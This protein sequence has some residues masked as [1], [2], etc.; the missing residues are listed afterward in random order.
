MVQL[1]P[2]V[3]IQRSIL[4]VWELWRQDRG[5]EVVDS[6]LERSYAPHEVLRCI[7][8]GLLCV[9]ENAMDRPTMSEVILML[10]SETAIPSPKQPAFLYRI[11]CVNTSVEQRNRASNSINDITITK[12][13]AR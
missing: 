7:Q 1:Q 5:M 11:S 10:S 3:L 8:I 2:H 4:Q 13:L 6:S 12:V 9:Q